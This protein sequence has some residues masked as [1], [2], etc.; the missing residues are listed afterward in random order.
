MLSQ[1]LLHPSEPCLFVGY[2]N[3]SKDGSPDIYYSISHWFE[4]EKFRGVDE[5][6][7]EAV[8]Q[9]PTASEAR[10]VANRYKDRCR[11][12][13]RAVRARV[14]KAGFMMAAEQNQDVREKLARFAQTTSLEINI[15][16]EEGKTI[17]GHAL[18]W[19]AGVMW[20]ASDI[21]I[22]RPARVLFAAA[23]KITYADKP[24]HIDKFISPSSISQVIVPIAKDASP[25]GEEYAIKHSLPVR[26]CY[27]PRGKLTPPFTRDLAQDANQIL[28]MERKGGKQ[29]DQ[30]I[31]SAKELGRTVKL[32]LL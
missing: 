8:L 1:S 15:E 4:S 9:A 29:F 27:A 31:T 24:T 3:P 23:R 32:A 30:L 10:K 20:D 12:D 16:F 21:Y 18:T 11:I 17:S 13:W 28:V 25:I 6:L 19:Y 5:V 2:R 22:N 7:R 26:Y 14:L